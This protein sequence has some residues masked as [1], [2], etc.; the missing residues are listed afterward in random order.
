MSGHREFEEIARELWREEPSLVDQRAFRTMARRAS[1]RGR[2]LRHADLG[3][4]LIL[5]MAVFVAVLSRPA[6]A[7]VLVGLLLFA[8][9]GWSS[10][11]RHMLGR[12][13]SLGQS[14]D[15]AAFLDHAVA[16]AAANVRRSTIGLWLFV[17]SILLGGLLGHSYKSQGRVDTYPDALLT[18]IMDWPQ[19]TGAAMLGAALLAVLSRS[20]RR[21][22]LEL[23]RLEALR[24]EYLDE[25]W[26][27]RSGPG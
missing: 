23:Q 6:P 8:A 22:R 1:V 24:R 21:Q 3:L 18:G 27:D 16:R 19:G 15:G 14:G 17:P 5:N 26:R 13:A 4:A 7:T 2:L 20:S 10:W 25:D 12:L 9:I 11:K